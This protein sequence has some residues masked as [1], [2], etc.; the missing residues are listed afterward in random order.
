MQQAL[1][2]AEKAFDELKKETQKQKVA[3][4]DMDY[5][6]D[7]LHRRLN[8]T[9]NEKCF[10]ETRL[11]AAETEILSVKSQLELERLRV[12]DLEIKNFKTNE[13]EDHRIR[14]V[15]GNNDIVSEL[16]KQI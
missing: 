5:S 11:K 10:Y 1:L 16:Y 8:L 15:K 12:E 4:R 14:T 6:N 7:D 13:K 2:E 9:E 3:V